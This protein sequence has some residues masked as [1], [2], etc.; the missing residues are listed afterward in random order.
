MPTCGVGSTLSRAILQPGVGLPSCHPFRQKSQKKK[1]KKNTLQIRKG[2]WRHLQTSFT[3]EVDVP[4]PN[5]LEAGHRFLPRSF[6]VRSAT[7]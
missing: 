1:K 5:S 7:S 3:Q 4:T 6:T 2:P